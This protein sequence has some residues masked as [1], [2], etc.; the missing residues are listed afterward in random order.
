MRTLIVA[1]LLCTASPALACQFDTDCAVGSKCIKGNGLY[2]VCA[3][4]MNPGNSYDQK[5]VYDPL[6]TNKSVG[7]TCNFDIDCGPG[8]KCVKSGLRGVCMR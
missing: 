5:P 1:I 7:N 4:G 8:S 2:G 6:D 3:G